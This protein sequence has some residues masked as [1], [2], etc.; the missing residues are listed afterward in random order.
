MKRCLILLLLATGCLPGAR[1]GSKL[2]NAVAVVVDDAVITYADIQSYIAAGVELLMRQYGRDPDMFKQKL[3]ALQQD[4]TEQL[5]E[6]QLILSDWK[7]AGYNLPESIIEDN[8]KDLI[9]EKYGDRLTLTK[10]L[11][12]QGMTYEGFRQQMREDFIVRVLRNKNVSSEIT[13]SPQKIESYYVQ[14]RDEYKQEDQ[15]KL[16]MIVLNENPA[17]PGSTRKLA[18]E[19]LA[20]IKDGSPFAEMATIY[21][22]GSQRSQS[23]DWGWVE[24]SVLRKELAEA[25]FTLKAGQV[26][27]VIE[28]PTA[29]YLMLVEQT[30]PAYIKSLPE[31]R[32]EVE[33][34]LVAEERSRLQKKYIDKLKAKSFVR[35]F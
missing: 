5:V 17:L 10:T 7:S 19:I 30:R 3:D 31:I 16:R 20:K 22:D 6:R 11:N 18:V 33:K 28:T 27:D 32:D 12:A 4:G 29:C 26:S 24:R 25:A 35:Y 15:V 9:R 23:G 34:S 1:A 2:A 8:I 14:H 21:S 13:V